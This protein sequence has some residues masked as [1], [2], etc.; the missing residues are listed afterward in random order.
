MGPVSHLRDFK[1]FG[2]C[3]E[4]LYTK[5]LSLLSDVPSFFLICLNVY[6]LSLMHIYMFICVCFKI[7]ISW[8][9]LFLSLPHNSWDLSSPF[10]D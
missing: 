8:G 1:E 3:G 5:K 4:N 7:E 2:N 9:L 10:Q 6:C